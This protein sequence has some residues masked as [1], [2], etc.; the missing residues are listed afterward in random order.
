METSVQETERG[1]ARTQTVI[2]NGR[3]RQTAER[4]LSYLEAIELAYPGEES[5]EL[6]CFTVDWVYPNGRGGSLVEGGKSVRVRDRMAVNVTRTDK[7]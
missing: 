3:P 1:C 2:V 5:T 4:R 6:I 7:S